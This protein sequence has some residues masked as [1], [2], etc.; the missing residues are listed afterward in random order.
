MPMFFDQYYLFLIIPTL[1]LSLFAQIKVKSTFAKYSKISCSRKITGQDAAAILLRSNR[2]NDVK[3]EQTAGS[4]TDHYDPS[5]KTLRL[6]QPVYAGH[7][8][9]FV[10]QQGVMFQ[11][12]FAFDHIRQFR[13][14]YLA[15]FFTRRVEPEK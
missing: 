9:P 11:M 14:A 4:L 12:R 6:S 7:G 10:G 15:I 3:I 8:D 5:S 13:Q 2:I 1:I